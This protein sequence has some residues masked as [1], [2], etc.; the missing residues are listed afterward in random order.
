MRN[1]R[2]K[3]NINFLKTKGILNSRFY[4]EWNKCIFVGITRKELLFKPPEKTYIDTK[5]GPLPTFWE[6]LEKKNINFRKTKG[7]LNSRFY[8]EWN[9]FTFV[10]IT[11]KE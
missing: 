11:L 8:R 10:G 5:G 7:I 2:K 3:K 1:F 6:I 4:R 9:K